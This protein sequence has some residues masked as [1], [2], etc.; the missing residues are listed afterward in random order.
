[1]AEIL[2]QIQEQI[3]VE[4]LTFVNVRRSAIWVDT[5]RQLQRKR[6]SPK[7]RI[8]VKFAKNEGRSEGAVD[9]GGPKR[10]FLRLVVKAANEDS[11]V[12]VGPAGC[13]SL[14][15]N[16]IGMYVVGCYCVPLFFH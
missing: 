10:E 4:E 15:P 5:C 14:Y 16:A 8:S 1:M 13:H 12:F 2:H 11:G 7:N 3:T 9:V 6:F